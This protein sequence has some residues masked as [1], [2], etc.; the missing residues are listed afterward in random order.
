MTD[1]G[2]AEREIR[3]SQALQPDA[4]PQDGLPD[5]LPETPGSETLRPETLG[6]DPT[7]LIE[8]AR[9]RMPFGKYANTPYLNMPEPYLTW[10]AQQGWPNGRL[11]VVLATLHEIKINGLEGLIRRL[12]TPRS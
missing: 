4:R 10:F 7:I 3:P 8:I 12:G 5:A 11:G 9:G 6:A 1:D 2:S